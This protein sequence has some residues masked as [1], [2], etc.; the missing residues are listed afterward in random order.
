MDLNKQLKKGICFKFIKSGVI[1]K[2]SKVSG[3]SIWFK[4]VHEDYPEWR[5]SK[6]CFIKLS[7]EFI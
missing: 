6:N 7:I 4:R 5:K 2:I 1:F 3:N